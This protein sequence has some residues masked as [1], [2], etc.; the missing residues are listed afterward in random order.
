MPRTAATSRPVAFATPA[1]FRAWLAKH[2]AGA[3]ELIVRLYKVHAADRG[4][5][6]RQALDEA[7]CFGWIDGVRH[8]LDPD[9]FSVRFTPR[10]PR[11]KWSAVNLRRVAE[12][13]QEG[14][15]APP[16]LA[17]HRARVRKPAGYSFESRPVELA[18]PFLKS[19]RANRA[20]WAY[21]QSQPP[22]YRRT[23]AFWVMSAKQEATRAR[24]LAQ[25]IECSA[26]GVPIRLLERPKPSRG[27]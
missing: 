4:V 27:K 1:R 3:T 9:S 8:G 14:R 25:L 15:M 6:Y 18:A 26:R 17:A 12:L 24:R 20:A 13:E 2:H 16:G 11:S 7:L 23:S 22:W 10:K 5:T 21:Y 19:L